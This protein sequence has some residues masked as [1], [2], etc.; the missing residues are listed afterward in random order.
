MS[1]KTLNLKGHESMTIHQW[2]QLGMILIV[3]KSSVSNTLK[4]FYWIK[5]T[6][7]T[8]PN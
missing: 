5:N 3:T 2:S 7:K 6:F 8:V 1:K 4:V